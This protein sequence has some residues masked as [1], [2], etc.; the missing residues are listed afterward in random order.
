MGPQ[1]TVLGR[2]MRDLIEIG[3]GL[4][5][6]VKKIFHMKWPQMK[7]SLLDGSVDAM[8]LGISM[9]PG[10]KWVTVPVYKEI[11]AAGKK[12]YYISYN[13]EI[14]DKTGK[15]TN[16]YFPP[17]VLPKDGVASGVPRKDILSFTD[18]LGVWAHREFDPALAYEL[19]RV[20][21]G[22]YKEMANITGA[23]KATFEDIIFDLI[24]V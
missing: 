24:A 14:M 16:S 1:P 18:D 11:V 8:V 12:P 2:S 15:A 17:Q 5:G 13:K 21:H 22:Y 4:K 23:A 6:K 10:G 9:R 7:D 3:Y 19:T 20:L